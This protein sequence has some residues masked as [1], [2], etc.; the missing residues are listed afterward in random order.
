MMSGAGEVVTPNSFGARAPGRHRCEVRF[1]PGQHRPFG[2]FAGGCPLRTLWPVTRTHRIAA[3]TEGLTNVGLGLLLAGVLAAD[4]AVVAARPGGGSWPF[5]LVIGS[6]VGALTLFRGRSPVLA[7]TAGLTVGLA[8]DVA[9]DAARLP[10]QPGVAATLGLLVLGAAAVRVVAARRAALVAVAG[11]AVLVAGRVGVRHEYILPLAFLGLLAWGGAL[12]V[13]VWLRF[14]DARH[15][16]AVDAA[17]R[18]ER[19]ELARELHDVVAHHVAGIV[20]QAQAARLLAAR[21]PETLEPTLAGIESAGTDALGAMRRVVGLLRDVSDPGDAA[22]V[23]HGPEALAGLIARFADHG[24][25][26]G[27]RLPDDGQASSWPPEVASTV[28]RVVQEALTNVVLHAQ[29][30]AEVTVIVESG[31]STV[32]VEVI[33]NGRADPAAPSWFSRRGGYGLVGMRERVE[34]LG[35]RLQAGPGPAGGWAVRAEVPLPAGSAR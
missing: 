5:E 22:G 4:T 9:A 14:V 1:R 2:R 11:A 12:G 6:I 7:V 24:P 30:A 23:T 33:D 3:R 21:R 27:L 16:L 18:D 17:R 28:Y 34:A 8:A 35:G 20:V 26:V 29:E 19:L 25:P 13:G 10:S 31:P 15:Q 32:T